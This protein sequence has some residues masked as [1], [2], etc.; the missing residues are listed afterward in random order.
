MNSCS[1]GQ[2]DWVVLPVR[3]H[4]NQTCLYHFDRTKIEHLMLLVEGAVEE[5]MLAEGQKSIGSYHQHNALP[6]S[7][8]TQM[9]QLQGGHIAPGASRTP[10]ES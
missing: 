2:L 10:S 4:E 3:L 8:S 1:E 5:T 9:K 7:S 6:A